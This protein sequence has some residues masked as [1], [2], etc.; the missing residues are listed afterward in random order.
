MLRHF[1]PPNLQNWNKKQKVLLAIAIASVLLNIMAVLPY[2][3]P[4]YVKVERKIFPPEHFSINTSDKVVLN[5]VCEATLQLKG[6]KMSMNE[7]K[8]L[9]ADII[10]FFQ[11]KRG[12]S[13]KN[14]FFTSY[15][16]VG[17][18]YYALKKNDSTTMDMLRDKAISFLDIKE[19]KLNYPIKKIDQAPI[20]ILLLNLYR[21]YNNDVY[22]ESAKSL[23]KTIIDMREQDGTIMYTSGIEYNYVDAVGMYVPFLMEYFKETADSL[24][25]E[26]VNFNMT[27]YYENG[28]NHATGIPFHGYNIKN[29]MHLGSANWGRGIGWYLLAAAYCP[30]INDPAL[31]NTL[32]KI[33]YTQFPGCNDHFDSSTALMFEIYKQSKDQSRKLSLDF[34]KPHI[35]TNGFVDDCSGDTYGLNSY[36]HTFGE[37]EL[38]NGFLLMLVSKFDNSQSDNEIGI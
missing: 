16:M 10:A 22:L 9:P 8:G 2:V 27:S 31:N 19:K 25:L 28:V 24:A 26:T 12:T 33:D 37:S 15:S 4:C 20:G 30:Q 11:K 35:L 3:K 1:T 6:V 36:S 13:V 17:L 5:K 7:N 34:I 18:S 23:F 21:W 38:C 29:G 32:S 14:N